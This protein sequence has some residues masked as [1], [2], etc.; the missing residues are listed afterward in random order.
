ML[1]F[2]SENKAMHGWRITFLTR[3]IYF[4]LT[5]VAIVKGLYPPRAVSCI[6]FS[7]EQYFET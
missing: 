6:L 2:K 7:Q 5:V 4:S 1:P 3:S